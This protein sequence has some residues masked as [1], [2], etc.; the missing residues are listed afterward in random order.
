M[1]SET[2]L[3]EKIILSTN[4]LNGP[5]APEPGTNLI[6]YDEQKSAVILCSTSSSHPGAVFITDIEYTGIRVFYLINTTS[7]L[8]K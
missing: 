1:N 6:L 7:T 8:F 3:T 5:K 4:T 2:P